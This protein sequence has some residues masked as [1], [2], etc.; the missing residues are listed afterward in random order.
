MMNDSEKYELP[1]HLQALQSCLRELNL[2]L[3]ASRSGRVQ[4]RYRADLSVSSVSF[5]LGE[6]SNH[7]STLDKIL[8]GSL[9]S[10]FE[11]AAPATKVAKA[12][13]S[14]AQAVHKF[15]ADFDHLAAAWVADEHVSG[16]QLLVAVYAHTLGE[17]HEMIIQLLAMLA[18]PVSYLQQR[19]L[20]TTG[21]V[22]LTIALTFTPALQLA[23][24]QNWM[25]Q[26][27]G[28]SAYSFGLSPSTA[29]IGIWEIL[30]ISWLAGAFF[31][32]GKNR[33]DD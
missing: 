3:Q 29:R 12:L 20:P 9:G 31:G 28:R 24:L 7:V 5:H 23:D 27:F 30:A 26:H 14:F 4:G 17:L 19:G 8:R 11:Q 22:N 32:D 21:K 1:A 2:C 33:R 25:Q 10:L 13:Q 16:Q 15:G 18:D 6:L